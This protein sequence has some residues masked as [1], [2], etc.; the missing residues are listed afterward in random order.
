[1]QHVLLVPG[2]FGFTNLGDL[3]YF[4]HV[5]D[6]L[7]RGFAARGLEA[8]VAVV[9]T[10]PT[11]SLPR[12]AARVAAT[13][14]TLP[15][16]G[17]PVHLVGHSSGGLDLR[18]LTSPGVALP[19]EVAVEAL[20]ARVRSVVTVTT[21]HHGTP[22]AAVFTGLLGQRLLQLLSLVTI[23]VLRFG[24]LPLTAVFKVGQV[25]AHLDGRLGL[26][27]ALLDELYAQLLADFSPERRDAV[28]AF[29]A[30][31]ESDRGLL[32]QLTPEGMA[33][34]NATAAPRPGLRAGS[35]VAMAAPP[36]V[37]STLRVGLDPAAQ[38]T[39]VMYQALH[40]LT[41][42]RPE[43]VPPCTDAQADVMRAAYGTVPDADANDGVVPT[44][45]QP[46]GT[47][48]HAARGDHLDV[49]GHYGAEPPHVDWLAT[50]TGF[51]RGAFEALWDD[52]MRFLLAE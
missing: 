17:A 43:E 48:L 27:G 1:M 23:Y 47:L 44:R 50:G 26:E 52:V 34:L 49:L 39:H 21:P 13:L 41:R 15:D 7:L 14:A 9:R 25:F 38:A 30:D 36:G 18:L 8:S 51:D 16:D 29:L 20:L 22:L 5:R 11:A 31:V 42:M 40:R 46:W 4:G 33:L 19:T 6:A 12:R 35:V 24:H 32:P 28:A 37:R 10:L 3:R 2:F 45:S